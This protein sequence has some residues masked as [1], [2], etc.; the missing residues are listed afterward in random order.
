MM[1]KAG[2]LIT[3]LSSGSGKTVITLGLLSALKQQGYVVGAAKVGPD[4]IDP[5]FH[6]A[7]CDTDCINLDPF[8]MSRAQI[9]ALSNQQI[10]AITGGISGS[11]IGSISGQNEACCRLVEGVMGL[12][13]GAANGTASSHQ[14][15]SWL[16]L[17]VILI[18]DI[19]GCA[20][21]AAYVAAGLKQQ[22]GEVRLGG[23]ILNRLGSAKHG[24]QVAK[25]CAQL[26]I[27]V[28]GQIRRSERAHI[29][30]RHLG[31]IQAGELQA[32]AGW[33]DFL[34]GLTQIITSDCDLPA[35]ARL[36][37]LSPR[38]ADENNNNNDD[39]KNNKGA[40]ADPPCLID[41]PG[42]RI[43]IASD[44]AFS[45]AYQH[46]LSGWRARGAEILPFS[47]IGDQG[48]RDDADFIYLPG[49]YPELH[50]PAISRA[51]GF[52]A[53]LKR[54][55]KA[56]IPIY[57]ECGGYMVLGKQ[58]ID[59]KGQ[60]FDMAGLLDVETSF[61]DPGLHLGYR[62]LTGLA[63]WLTGAWLGHEFHYTKTVRQSGEPLF[64]AKDSH[65]TDLG[66]MGLVKGRVCG[67]YAHLI[68]RDSS[69]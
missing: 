8:A 66:P 39:D 57:G 23:V 35:I 56:D 18:L 46:L 42:Q 47:P 60:G 28:L 43:A 12:F 51:S 24:E 53:G 61:K 22:M 5:A 68:A 27:P 21:T 2:A 14:L 25:R 41:P 58:I 13:D 15:A 10:A 45:F 9:S 32:S 34:S 31:L 54:A 7:L 30:A 33:Q 36:A 48:P 3:A 38:P 11:N 20:D 44:P 67:S 55:A 69:V 40:K 1:A 63:G 17:P 16:G 64:T 59:E 29:P 50:L 19:K 26:G 62:R 4:Y 65:G 49:G 37:N 52:F 6:S